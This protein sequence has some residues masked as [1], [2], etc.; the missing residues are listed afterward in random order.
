MPVRERK[1]TH[2]NIKARILPHNDEA[3]KSVLGCVLISEDAPV[4]ILSDLKSEDFYQRAHQDIFTA[5]LN[6]YVRNQPVDI[7]TLVQEVEAMG[8]MDAVGGI[9]YLS[10]LTDAIPSADNFKYYVDIVKKNSMLRRLIEAAGKV[11]D[12][13]FSSDPEDDALSLAERE[14]YALSEKEGRKTLTPMYEAV[15]QAVGRLEEIYK[16]P[17]GV[18]GVPIEYKKL[19]AILNGF[20]PSD[21]IVI[22][23]RPGEGKTS[24]GMN[25]ITYAALSGAR[26]TLSGNVDPYKCAVF[27]L[28]M[29]STQIANR[30]LCSVAKVDMSKANKGQLTADEWRRLHDARNR[31]AGAQIY[32]DDNANTTPVEI[33]SKC[34]RLKREKGLDLVMV[35]YLQLMSSGKKVDSRQQDVS[36]ISRAMKL[37]A[38]ELQVPILLLSQLNRVSTQRTGADK[39]PR[40]TDLRESGSIEQDADIVLFIYR[41]H[42]ARDESVAENVRNRVE[43]H[44]AK[45]RNGEMGRVPVMWKGMYTT[46]EDINDSEGVRQLEKNAPTKEGSFSMGE[47][48]AAKD[49]F[50]SL[51]DKI[52]VKSPDELKE[53]LNESAE[54]FEDFV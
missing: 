41:E 31:I 25:F 27:S 18:S 43:I 50:V 16:N 19:N 14:I 22:G 10:S 3:E 46:F 51:A 54:N 8:K 5:M 29:S 2:P 1:E 9:N 44:V 49:D 37:A 33:L 45:H 7:V 12:T 32:I 20:Q 17:D 15:D 4:A 47:E 34:R 30:M 53:E 23:A 42:D 35:D 38:K 11:M 28:E 36:E 48:Y 6:V 52:D 26:K 40:L 21:L 24:L 13:A 39:I